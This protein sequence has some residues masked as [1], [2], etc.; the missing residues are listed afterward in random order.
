MEIV[1]FYYSISTKERQQTCPKWIVISRH[2]V[3]TSEV[4]GLNYLQ[5]HIETYLALQEHL[6][7]V[8][9][10]G[11]TELMG[12]GG[13]QPTKCHLY[14]HQSKLTYQTLKQGGYAARTVKF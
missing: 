1:A 2:A 11:T 10:D 8:K 13:W 5:R 12:K 9:C 3:A 7:L 4:H 14:F 6:K